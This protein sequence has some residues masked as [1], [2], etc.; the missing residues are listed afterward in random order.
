[1]P[2]DS[3]FSK[4]KTLIDSRKNIRRK[5]KELGI[6]IVQMGKLLRVDL[7]LLRDWLKEEGS[8][9]VTAMWNKNVTL[10]QDLTYT[11]IEVYYHKRISAL[12]Y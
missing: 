11:Y 6:V 7:G 4:G 2:K 8:P 9:E 1:M 5:D 12:K 3:S 10:I